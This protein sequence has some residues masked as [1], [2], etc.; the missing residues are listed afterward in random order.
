MWFWHT[1]R[2]VGSSSLAWTN[3]VFSVFSVLTNDLSWVSESS[4]HIFLFL[5]FQIINLVLPPLS[6]PVIPW[7]SIVEDVRRCVWSRGQRCPADPAVLLASRHGGDQEP[8]CGTLCPLKQRHTRIPAKHSDSMVLYG[9]EHIHMQILKHNFLV[10]CSVPLTDHTCVILRRISA[11]RS[12]LWLES[13]K[14][15][16]WMRMSR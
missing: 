10:L 2:A 1:G 6:S 4:H 16:S 15:W 9:F 3:T 11:C 8:D 5:C 12:Y 13:R 7:C 14:S